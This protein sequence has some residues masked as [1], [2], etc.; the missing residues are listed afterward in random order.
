MADASGPSS[1]A[2]K[3]AFEKA[4]VS[5]EVAV[6]PWNRAIN[7]AQKDP[8]WIGVYPEYY[9]EDSDA[10]KGG[11]RCLFSK[12]FGVSPVGFVQRTGLRLLLVVP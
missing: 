5:A 12:S 11:D 7:L 9:A 10:E 8:E 2:V 4:G 6:F 3:A 1:D